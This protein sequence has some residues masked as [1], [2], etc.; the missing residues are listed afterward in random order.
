MNFCFALCADCLAKYRALMHDPTCGY[1]ASIIPFSSLDWPDEHPTKDG[2]IALP[3]HEE[4]RTSI[5]RLAAARTRL[6]ETG[7]VP[8]ESKELWAEAQRMIP[9][10]SG[11]LRLSLNQEQRLTL[12]RCARIAVSVKR[13]TVSVTAM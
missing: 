10:W 2:V 4:C 12:K 1:S 7:A 9:N 13:P 8:E 6:W 11:F 3:A 5:V